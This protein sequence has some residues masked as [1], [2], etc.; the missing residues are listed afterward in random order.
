MSN[1][2]P[3]GFQNIACAHMIFRLVGRSQLHDIILQ[4][5]K[6]LPLVCFRIKCI[7][8]ITQIRKQH[9]KDLKNT[10]RWNFFGI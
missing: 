1:L 9:R 10:F 8:E 5:G 6:F 4:Q 7:E 2:S 3:S